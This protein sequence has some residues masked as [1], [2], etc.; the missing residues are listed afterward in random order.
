MPK[1]INAFASDDS[2]AN[3]LSGLAGQIFGGNV[4]QQEVYRQMALGKRRENEN[5]PI[6]ADAVVAGDPAA[7]TRAG[8]MSGQDPKFTGG[9]NQFM[10]VNQHGPA[11]P[12][13][14]TA[15]MAVPG[16]NYGNTIQGTNAEMA[17]RRTIAQ[18]TADR[19]LAG[20]KY[21]A[22]MTPHNVQDPNDPSRALIVPRSQAV[23]GGQRPVLSLDQQRGQT[24]AAVVPTMSPDDQ[25]RFIG[26]DKNP[27]TLWVYQTPDGRQGTTADGQRDISNGAAL[28]PGSK[29]MRLEGANT[30][31]LSGN[32]TVD[33]QLLE[34]RVA[35]QTAAA[36]IDGLI[37]S[38]NQP[39]ADQA[40]GYLG[41]VARSF[42]D[43]R[44]QVEAGARLFGSPD[45][46]DTVF[47]TP[48]A[49]QAVD[50]AL[51]GSILA[52]QAVV[53]KARQLGIDSAIIRS[54]I[55]DLAYMTAKA[56]DPGGRV[57]TDDIRRAA[58]TIGAAIM[59]PKSAVPVLTDLKQRLINGQQIRERTTQ[60]MFPGVRSQGAPA[61]GAPT[62]GAPGGG[63]SIRID[64]NGNIIQ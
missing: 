20:I 61:A 34:S 32:S 15:T 55:Q 3:T 36:S 63:Q 48:E 30:E 41:R 29:V 12:Q 27:S 53:A 57:S 21:T 5:I 51:Q 50:Q 31:G 54:Q 35:T 59:D 40:V 26:V 22:D 64:V 42:N 17:N 39:N 58:E 7:A 19:Q 1:I 2:L 60:Q 4:A 44:S 38:L 25:R 11:S 13:A 9:Y 10:R 14:L 6:L 43:I 8:I 45:T 28:P 56:Q 18:M 46:K 23:V 52:N 47:S 24:A 62:A 33:R 16:A 49:K 37:T